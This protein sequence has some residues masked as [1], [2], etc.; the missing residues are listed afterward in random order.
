MLSF[1]KHTIVSK[2]VLNGAEGEGSGGAE[3]RRVSGEG[4]I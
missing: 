2:L 1:C 4:T 3:V